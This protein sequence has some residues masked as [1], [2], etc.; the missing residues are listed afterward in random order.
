VW[1][2]FYLWWI[3]RISSNLYRSKGQIKNCIC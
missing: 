1:S 3:F 2:I